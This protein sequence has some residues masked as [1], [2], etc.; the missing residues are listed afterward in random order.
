MELIYLFILSRIMELRYGGENQGK[1]VIGGVGERR[2]KKQ[3]EL[4]EYM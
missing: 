4:K 2:G 3:S 1:V